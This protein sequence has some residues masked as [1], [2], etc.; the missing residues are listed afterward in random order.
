MSQKS[1]WEYFRPIYP[2]T[3]LRRYIPVLTDPWDV[4]AIGFTEVNSVTD[5]GNSGRGEFAHS[6]KVTD[7][8]TT[9][10]EPRSW[11]RA[12]QR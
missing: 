1:R 5:S 8:Q 7:I 4:G 10:T 11:D 3:L 2:G 6:L 12:K 9:W